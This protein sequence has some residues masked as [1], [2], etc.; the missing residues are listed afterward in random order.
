M[1]RPVRPRKV[2]D[3]T[4]AVRFAKWRG[5]IREEVWQS[6]S[7]EVVRYNLAFICHHLCGVDNGRV[8]G[9]DN[10]HGDH[11]RHFMGQTMPI[12]YAGYDVLLDQFLAE[13]EALRKETR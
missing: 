10:Q 11:H 2:V 9:Y 4:T 1:A 8:L 7:G 5:L 6:E 13:V 12:E 3:E